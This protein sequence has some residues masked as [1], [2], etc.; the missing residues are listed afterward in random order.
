MWLLNDFLKIERSYR[1]LSKAVIVCACRA[2]GGKM[3][4]LSGGQLLRGRMEACNN[5]VLL[6]HKQ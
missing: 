6:Q 5:H 4:K 3:G 1:T 2:E